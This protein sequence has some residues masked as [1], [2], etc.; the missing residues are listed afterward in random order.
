[1]A[2]LKSLLKGASA[3]IFAGIVLAQVAAAATG[4]GD[5]R[6]QAGIIRNELGTTVHASAVGMSQSLRLTMNDALPNAWVRSRC[7]LDQLSGSIETRHE[8]VCRDAA[9]GEI[10]EEQ[11]EGNRFLQL[12]AEARALVGRLGNQLEDDLP[13][14]HWDAAVSGFRD[15]ARLGNSD[16]CN[17]D[18]VR[19]VEALRDPAEGI[20]IGARHEVLDEPLLVTA[21]R[22]G[23]DERNVDD[24]GLLADDSMTVGEALVGSR[25]STSLCDRRDAE[26]ARFVLAA[27][28]VREALVDEAAA[29][30]MAIGDAKV[31]GVND[32]GLDVWSSLWTG[33]FIAALA[34]GVL[35]W[36]LAQK[37]RVAEPV[38]RVMIVPENDRQPALKVVVEASPESPPRE[39]HRGSEA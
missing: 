22:Y 26:R 13:A 7:D 9:L 38:T 23:L 6:A 20:P 27:T 4:Y 25:T 39:P 14:S 21:E 28:A 35:L 17:D 3:F 33:P 37:I 19:R 15:L 24:L 29:I 32:K 2:V 30:A 5:D 18:R 34:L 12:G 8:E 1:M 36:L 31:E 16:T 11:E 10:M